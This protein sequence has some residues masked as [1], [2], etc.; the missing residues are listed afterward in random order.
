MRRA[1]LF[2]NG[3]SQAVRLPKDYRFQGSEVYIKA[4]GR[5]VILLPIDGTWESLR[6]SLDLFTDD[7]LAERPQPQPES[8]KSFD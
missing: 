4:V 5:A 8:R 1:K 7:F 3:S 6:L 2:R